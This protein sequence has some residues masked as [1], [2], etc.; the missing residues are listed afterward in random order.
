M[1]NVSITILL[2]ALLGLGLAA[3]LFLY[4]GLRRDLRSQLQKQRVRIDE[5]QTQLWAA[6]DRPVREEARLDGAPGPVPQLRSA[7]NIN[8]RIQA[9]RLFRRGEDMAHIA[10]ALGLPQREAELLVRV[11]QMS[12][13]CAGQIA[14][15]LTI[16]TAGETCGAS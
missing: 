3:M 12:S 5:I 14:D 11:H 15:V 6:I 7:L 13:G 8:K 2:S 4:F 1:T 10:D 16:P 9:A